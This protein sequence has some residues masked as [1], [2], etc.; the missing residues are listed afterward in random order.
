MFMSVDLPEPD[1][2]D[3]RDELAGVDREVDAVQ[4]FDRELAGAV[5]LGD[6]GEL[7]QRCRSRARAAA[8]GQSQRARVHV[9]FHIRGCIRGA[10]LLPDFAAAAGWPA[11]RGAGHDLLAGLEAR[12]DLRRDAA[13][14]ADAHFA[15]LDRAVGFTTRTMRA[16]AGEARARI[17]AALAAARARPP[18]RAAAALGVPALF[19][20]PLPLSHGGARP[21]R[22]RPG[23]VR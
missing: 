16:A 14:H 13:H 6:A 11:C 23:A 3:D 7:D 5:G 12:H 19:V 10:L 2:A 1:C 21:R 15:V 9:E 22:C 20:A 17:D 8:H 18:L 4:H